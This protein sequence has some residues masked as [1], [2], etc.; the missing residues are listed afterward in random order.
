MHSESKTNLDEE[1]L[2]KIARTLS[3]AKV[4]KEA[5]SGDHGSSWTRGPQDLANAYFAIVAICHQTSPIGER[6]LEGMVGSEP[7]PGWNYLKE[8]FLE[9][10]DAKPEW[11][12]PAFW[13]RVSPSH[14]SQMYADQRFGLT[15]NRV[16]ERSYLLNDLGEKLVEEGLASIDEAFR[17]CQSTLGGEK[18]FLEYLRGF[19]AY[20]DPVRKKALFFTSL[21]ATE[22]G[23]RIVDPERL[24]SPV[25]YHELRGHLR[26]GTVRVTDEGLKQKIRLGLTLS[27]SE[28]TELRREVQ[29]A[30]SILAKNANLTSSVIHYLLWN[31]FRNCCPRESDKTHC[32]SCGSSCGLPAQYKEMPIYHARCVFGDVCKSAGA[33]DKLVDPAYMGHYY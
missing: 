17:R 29:Q 2:A 7:K 11:A 26:I 13:R 4:P 3:A 30:N 12:T 6:R 20:S 16:N 9:T 33:K 1:K 14:L 15:L 27:P 8:R 28:D 21:A 5:E 19:E 18:G 10:A 22:C 25:D 32:T 23:W 31:V 24:E